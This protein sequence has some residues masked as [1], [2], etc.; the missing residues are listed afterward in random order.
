MERE[1][2]GL[3]VDDDPAVCELIHCVLVSTGMEVLS[4]P[5]GE[6]ARELLREESLQ[7]CSSTCGW[8]FRTASS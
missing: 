3:A 2:R 7:C 1:R 8:R 6:E 4:L 5:T